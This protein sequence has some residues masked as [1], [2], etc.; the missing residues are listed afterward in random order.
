[1]TQVFNEMGRAVPVTVIAAGPCIVTEVRNKDKHG[2]TAIQL[3]FGS[4]KAKLVEKIK[5]KEDRKSK[6]VINKPIVGF[7]E[8]RDIKPMRYLREFRLENIDDYKIGQE[9]KVTIFNN[10]E[11]VDVVGRSKGKGFAGGMKRHGFKGGPRSHGSMIHR[12]PASSGSTDAARTIKGTKKPGR[13]GFDNVTAQGL[14]I[15]RVDGEKNLLLIKGSIPGP[16]KGLLIIRESCKTRKAEKAAKAAKA[17]EKA[18]EKG[19]RK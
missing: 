11:F 6:R 8:K 5:K 19:G 1:M 18:P 7:F 2:Y 13:L 14:Q 4:V 9:I 15:V 3:G 12:Q 10:G 17:A 16:P